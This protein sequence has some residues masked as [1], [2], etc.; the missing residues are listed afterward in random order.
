MVGASF[1]LALRAHEAARAAHRKRARRIPRRSRASTNARPRSATARGRSSRRSACGARCRATRRRSAPS[2]SPT[3]DDSASRGSMRASRASTRS[4]TSCR[5]ASSARCLWQALRDAPNIDAR[6][7]GAAEGREPR[8]ATMSCAR[9]RSSTARPRRYVRRSPSRPTEPGS[10]LRASAGIDAAVEDYEQVAIVVNAATERPDNGEAFERFTSSGPLAVLA[11]DEDGRRR[12][13]RHLGRGADARRGADGARRIGVRRRVAVGIR[14]ACGPMD[15]ASAGATPIHWRLSRAAET[16]VRARR[17][18][19]QRRAGVAPGRGPGVQSRVARRGDAR[20]DAGRAGATATFRPA[21]SELLGKF[22][23]WRAEDRSGVTRFTDGLVKLFGKRHARALGLVRNFGLLLFDLSPG[24]QTRAVAR[25]LG[26][27]GPHAA[28]R[29]RPAARMNVRLRRG[30]GRR[31]ARSGS[32]AAICSRGS[33][34]HRGAPH[35]RLRPA[36]CPIRS[37]DSPGCRSTCAC[38]RCRAPASGSCAPRCLDRTSPRRAPSLTNACRCG[39]PTCRRM[40]AMR[41]CST[42]RRWA[43][44]TSASS[45]RTRCCR[46]ALAAPRAAPASRFVAA[47]IDALAQE[48]DATVLRPGRA[49]HAGRGSSSAPTARNRA[50]ASS[51]AFRHTRADYGQ[52]AIVAMVTTARPHE[53]TAWQRF[54]GDGTLA[55]LP[56]RDGRSSIVWSLPTA[57]AE[58]LVDVA[59][60]AFER[61]LEQDFDGALGKVHARERAAEVP[62]VAPVAP[63]RYVTL[64]RR[65]GGRRGA[66]G[67]SARGAG[68]EPR[69]ARR[70]GARRRARR[71]ECEREDIGAERILRR[72]ERWRRSEND[73]MSGA[74]DVFDRLARARQRPCRRARAA[75]HAAGW[76]AAPLAKRVFIERA[77]GLAGELPAAAR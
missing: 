71:R 48:R 46:R 10:V 54:L 33:V 4:A 72:Y 56:L 66:R 69:P 16:V 31:R 41:W 75:R 59:P 57:R 6:G 64:A 32:R 44:A 18:H 28:P 29:A 1:A 62:A 22:A 63:D 65:A 77:M 49:M 68:R 15:E 60:E 14:L 13:R 43:S 45:P 12:I 7:A 55:F 52:T 5:T 37:T 21:F 26:L 23:A 50:C 24:R 11:G 20:G 17:A 40:A 51:R 74:I 53:H 25:E 8:C 61:E 30:R 67:A 35:C 47:E 34:R 76:A 38:S 2:M 73:L 36:A 58:K 27:R 70:R 39:T 42:P 9:A 19:R 3:R